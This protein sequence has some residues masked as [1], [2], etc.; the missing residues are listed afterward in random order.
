MLRDGR[1]HDPDWD[2]RFDLVLCD[3][4]CSGLGT[5]RKKP[6]IRYKDPAAI[7]GLPAVQRAILENAANYVKPGGVLLY[8]T[9]TILREENE[10]VTGGFL[11]AHGEFRKEPFVLPGLAEENDGALRLWPQRH[12]TDGFYICK[13]RKT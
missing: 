12:S 8:A 6:D 4:P 7:A 13:L 10:A 9:C 5:I 2:G 11:A 1:E 3:V